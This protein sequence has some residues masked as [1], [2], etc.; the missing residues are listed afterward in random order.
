MRNF[1]EISPDSGILPDYAPPRVCASAPIA[2]RWSAGRRRASAGRER[3]R[4][5]SMVG[6]GTGSVWSPDD[7]CRRVPIHIAD[8]RNM[9]LP[10]RGTHCGLNGQALW[11]P[12]F[13]HSGPIFREISA[14]RAPRQIS[15]K[16]LRNSHQTPTRRARAGRC[17]RARPVSFRS[18]LVFSNK[19]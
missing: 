7:V 9:S 1:H 8:S 19:L 13:R 4:L 10:K 6:P 12:K 3:A 16:I 2:T 17:S 14:L 11:A 18:I 5:R 15:A